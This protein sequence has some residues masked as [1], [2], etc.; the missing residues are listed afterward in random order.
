MPKSFRL[1]T[2]ALL[3][4]ALA[5]ACGAARPERASPGTSRV[6]V[7]PAAAQVAPLGSAAFSA[8]VG[9]AAASVSWSVQEGAAGGVITAGGSYTAPATA[10]TYHVVATT[11]AAPIQT[12]TATV[13]VTAPPVVTVTVAP[14]TPS[15]VPGGTVAF[16]A[17]VT[18]TGT[19]G[20]TWS[21]QEGAAGGAITAGGSYTAP[22]TAGTYHVRATSMADASKSGTATVTVTAP[23]ADLA[24]QLQVLSTHGVY[25]GHQSIGN[26]FLWMSGG[27]SS[28][29]NANTGPDPALRRTLDPAE[30]GPG[31]FAE[32]FVGANFDPASKIASFEA[33]L[34]GGIGAKV[35]VALMKFCFVDFQPGVA[36]FAS[37]T[38][39]TL[40]ASYRAMIARLQAD[41][42]GVLF[43][44]VTAPLVVYANGDGRNPLREE[45][46]ALLR[47]TYAG[48]EPIWDLA[49][50]ESTRPDGGREIGGDGAPALYPGYD[51]GDGG[52][53]NE[54]GR[55]AMATSLVA[56]LAGQ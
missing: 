7:V 53:P 3:C 43:V 25:F 26:M 14:S 2:S 5:T 34:R 45:Y 52:H 4:G 32:N 40:F 37:G 56:F 33:Q 51:D 9:G 11:T 31:V 8:S 30:M 54:A 49:L 44:H 13:T 1:V 55:H 21:V 28:I 38:A 6:D 24:A 48:T 39:A 47:S 19:T 41:Y 27:L 22:A 23:P 15:V 20:V 50:L 36:Y 10:G 42:P 18:G 12:G 29:L 17:T 35:D 16:T 46:N